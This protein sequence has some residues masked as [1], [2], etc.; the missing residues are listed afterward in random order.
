MKR[1]NF[2]TV[3]VI[4]STYNSPE[5]LRISLHSIISQTILPLEVIV[6]DDGSDNA[7][8]E[9]IRIIAAGTSVPVIHEWQPDQGF[10]KSLILNKAIR[11]ATGEYIIFIDGDIIVDRH[12]VEDHLRFARPGRFIT[13]SRARL[14]ADQTAKV[15]RC[16]DDTKRLPVL[17]FSMNA[18]RIPFLSHLYSA[19][20]KHD[21]T[22]ARGCNFAVWRS[23]LINTN[24]FN[25]DITGWGREDS[26]LS[27]RLMWSGVKKRFIKF[28]AIEHHLY[29]PE[30]SRDLEPRN[31]EIMKAAQTGKVVR[32]ANGIFQL[33]D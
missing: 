17:P 2:P 31:Y 19:R 33:T 20:K 24:G 15:I 29:H 3:T 23:D 12:F 16:Y 28:S 5:F 4:V 14:S 22:Y 8:A 18:V 13:G 10:R 26:E 21:G 25:N 1:K 27:W 6:A 9:V 11:R 7:T 32:A 30:Y